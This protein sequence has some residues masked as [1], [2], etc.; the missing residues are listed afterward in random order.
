V[1]S[2][3]R[4]AWAVTILAT[5]VLT[6][7]IPYRLTDGDSCLYAA[8]AHDIARGGSWVAP[9]WDFHGQT[10]CFHEHPPGAF[11]LSAIVE[12]L[13]APEATASLAAN[14]LW[15]FAAV[16]GVVALARLFVS[17]ATANVAG[18]AFLLHIV[19]LKYVQRAGLEIPLAATAAWTLAAGLRLGRSRWWIGAAG[20]SLAGAFL[21]RG[22]FGA[23]PA[24]VLVYAAFEPSLRPP[25]RR[26]VATFALATL[27]LVAFDRAHAAATGHGFWAAYVERQVLP[28][29]RTDGT[30]HSV[31][32]E[33]WT[34]YI[35][36]TLLYTLPWSIL[37]LWRLTRRDRPRGD[38]AAAWRLAGVWIALTV[39][40]A[41]LSSRAGSRYVFQVYVATSLLAALA[42]GTHLK[43][44][45]AWIVSAF[46]VLM[47]PAQ[48]IVKSCFHERGP[49][50]ETAAAME[51][52]RGDARLAG[53]EIRGPFQPEDDR[54]KSLLRFHTGRPVVSDPAGDMRGLRWVP[55]VDASYPFG[56]VI[57]VTPL[58][59]LVVYEP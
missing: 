49:W 7:L 5:V 25:P 50:W 13:G 41:S 28:S 2:G 24:A 36:R 52:L 12:A 1:T 51:D 4:F 42:V 15:T 27:V 32:G 40:G 59:A 48:V 3:R 29:L 38:A 18:L 10:A 39:I 14:A 57:A 58:G 33:T 19:V 31:E 8:L 47:L 37:P 55:G 16:A 6:L 17:G 26:L 9:Q 11:W 56:R 20:I 34:Y 53:R 45:F 43:P 54:L 46:V 30:A 35:G 44:A 22:V 21:V 23:V